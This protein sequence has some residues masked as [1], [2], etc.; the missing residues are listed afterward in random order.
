MRTTRSITPLLLLISLFLSISCVP[1]N[2]QE[3]A[4]QTTAEMQDAA[5]LAH[6]QQLGDSLVALAQAE[7]LQAVGAAMQSGGPSYA[8]DF[9]NI[10]APGLVADLAREWNCEIRR[11]SLKARNPDHRPT[12]DELKILNWYAG[13]EGNAMTSTV[14]R[15]GELVH[16][17]S[18]IQIKMPACL[19][20]HGTPEQEI[21]AATFAMIREKYPEDEA[22][23]YKLNDFRG[24]W[25]L[26]FRP[27]S[28]TNE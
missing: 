18:P 21:D 20:C 28:V 15:E 7:M 3:T 13:L 11:T 12:P 5:I 17:A 9:C 4:D 19:S 6:H 25:H 1:K 24:M 23:N 14:W 16:Y 8:I 10:H 26:T 27:E 22:V 2:N